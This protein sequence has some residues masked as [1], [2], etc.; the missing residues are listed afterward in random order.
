[1]S[2]V[3][4]IGSKNLSSLVLNSENGSIMKDTFIKPKLRNNKNKNKNNDSEY[5]IKN[6]LDKAIKNVNILDICGITLSENDPTINNLKIKKRSMLLKFIDNNK[7][8]SLGFNSSI[9]IGDNSDI[10]K[11]LIV[12]NINKFENDKKNVALFLKESNNL[13]TENK[14]TFDLIISNNYNS[15]Y[16]IQTLLFKLKDNNNKILK[17]NE[18]IIIN[19]DLKSNNILKYKVYQVDDIFIITSNPP[20]LSKDFNKDYLNL[21]NKFIL[22]F[23]YVK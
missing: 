13:L 2:I 12:S 4:I 11:N 14:E 9:R 21:N 3:N 10:D 20:L 7:L 18:D 22:S 23:S 6:V 5:K 1:M 15:N 17:L 16:S 8:K 19:D